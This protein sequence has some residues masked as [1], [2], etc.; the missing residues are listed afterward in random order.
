[1][2]AVCGYSEGND[3]WA[4]RTAYVAD[5]LGKVLRETAAVSCGHGGE[6]GCFRME[7]GG[8]EADEKDGKEDERE[9]IGIGED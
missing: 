8:T 4:E 2:A 5:K 3:K 9:S 1:V 7:N 6:P